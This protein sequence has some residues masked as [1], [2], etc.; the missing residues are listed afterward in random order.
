MEEY[1]A[2]SRIYD[3]IMEE[4]PY[5]LW[6]ETITGILTSEGITGGLVCELGCGTGSMT[7]RLANKGYDMTG[8][9][10]STEMLQEALFKR[11]E[12]GLPILYL[13]QDMREFELYGTMRAFVSVCDSMN[14]LLTPEDF[15]ETL[16]L[17]NNYLDP[18]GIFVFD[19]KTE[20]C[21]KNIL[22]DRTE[23]GVFEDSAYIWENV[24]DEENALN[25]YDLTIFEEAENGLYERFEETHVQRAYSIEE[26]KAFAKAAGM[27]FVKAMDAED[28]GPVKDT[29]ERV[30]IVLRE[31]GKKA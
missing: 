3:E 12:S 19:L 13:C 21:F 23:A 29:T 14:Y 17:I 7:E 25:E 5:D 20:H 18:G 22:G 8:I 6:C 1:S 15:T 9:D 2:F 31:Q 27:I 10:R 30:L 16:K 24:Y 11:D 4:I 26:I 28:S